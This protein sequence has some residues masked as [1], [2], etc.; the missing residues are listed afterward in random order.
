MTL[1]QGFEALFGFV[2]IFVGWRFI[3]AREIPATSEGSSTPLW[4]IRGR[5]AVFAGVVVIGLGLALLA[6]AAGVVDLP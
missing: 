6:V 1:L 5:D 2:L 4:W 3:H